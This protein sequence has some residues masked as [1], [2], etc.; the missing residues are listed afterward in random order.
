[1]QIRLYVFQISPWV[2]APKHRG[3]S[4]SVT[5]G[6]Q[7]RSRCFSS[8]IETSLLRVYHLR[9]SLQ[10]SGLTSSKFA[11]LLTKASQIL[12]LAFE[13]KSWSLC[14]VNSASHL[15]ASGISSTSKQVS[16]FRSRMYNVCHHN[17]YLPRLQRPL[18]MLISSTAQATRA[19]DSFAI[20]PPLLEDEAGIT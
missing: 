13:L 11:I 18:T 20:S 14:R 19:I 1:M 15:S 5:S 10:V 17:G 3:E 4:V 6:R 12:R 8:Q 7:L 9:L 16:V 2:V